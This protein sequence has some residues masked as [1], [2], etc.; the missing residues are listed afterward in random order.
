MA[1]DEKTP[2]PQDLGIYSPDNWYMLSFSEALCELQRFILPYLGVVPLCKGKR[3]QTDG[4]RI[5]LNSSISDFAD[6]KDDLYEN[7]NMTLYKSDALHEVLHW[8]EGSF[9][10]DV[11]ELLKKFPNPGLA[12]SIMNGTDDA[13]I[14]NNAISKIKPHDS[15]LIVVSNQYYARKRALPEDPG[16]RVM[17]MY[18]MMMIA[19]GLPSKF[20]PLNAVTDDD[21]KITIASSRDVAQ[22]EKETLELKIES[23]KLQRKGIKTGRDV[24]NKMLEMGFTTYNNPF[25]SVVSVLEPL[26]ELLTEAFPQ[27]EKTFP[28]KGSQF[29]TVSAPS[30]G[31]KSDSNSGDGSGEGEGQGQIAYTGFHGDVHD[32]SAGKDKG[33]NIEEIIKATGGAGIPKSKSPDGGNQSGVGGG[34]GVVTSNTGL[35]K[36]KTWDDLKK[37]YT[38]VQLLRKLAYAGRNE[39]FK[40]QLL[41]YAHIERQ[42]LEHFAQLRPNQMQIIRRTQDPDA[43]NNEALV[44]MMADDSVI[45][46]AEIFDSYRTNIRDTEWAILLDISGSTA[47]KLE[48]G[49]RVIDLEKIA[50]G[51][52]YKSLVAIGDRVRMYAFST[53]TWTAKETSLYTLTGLANLGALEPE[54]ANAD[55]VAIRGVALELNQSNAMTKNLIVLSDGRP[56]AGSGQAGDPVIDTSV[57]FMEAESLG[58]RTLYFN[59]DNQ[60]SD[61]FATLSA[62][63]TYAQSFN[64]PDKL[65]SGVGQF[66]VNYG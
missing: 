28:K 36:I 30:A 45:G 16:H 29:G 43:I 18:D 22:A 55:G 15:R 26:Y 7:R 51:L 10:V 12:H 32:F 14:E 31:N 54:S 41:A 44:E 50:A 61:Y 5:I 23:E 3:P 40:Q 58:I 56:V 17:E 19:K 2:E 39:G 48:S 6:P 21:G 59:V 66:V 25:G 35:V 64:S 57:A 4:K 37:A 53:D 62:N 8:T 65:P 20:K 33:G 24:L 1:D 13:R 49:K 38:N 47:K 60:A 27:I 34:S 42:I 63:A 46:D 9:T 11:R 52:M